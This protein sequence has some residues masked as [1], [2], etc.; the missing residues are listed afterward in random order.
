MTK[1]GQPIAPQGRSLASRITRD[2]DDSYGRLKDDDSDPAYADFSEPAPRRGLA[3]R[4]T[5][6]EE[7]LEGIN[8]RGTAS[9]RGG[10]SIRGVAGGA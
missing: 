5:R 7:E 3:S 6:D 9:Q 2:T 4:M 1:D 8:I 10:F